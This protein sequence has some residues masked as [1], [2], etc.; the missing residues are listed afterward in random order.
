[1]GQDR[2]VILTTIVVGSNPSL[3]P[4]K[5]SE[6]KAE[7]KHFPEPDT[8]SYPGRRLGPFKNEQSSASDLLI[9]VPTDHWCLQPCPPTPTF[10]IQ[11]PPTHVPQPVGSTSQRLG[12]SSQQLQMQ[13]AETATQSGPTMALA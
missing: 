13:Q 5:R 11:K 3:E 8:V 10:G 7:N 1:M 2:L 6:H 9:S 12:F 4:E